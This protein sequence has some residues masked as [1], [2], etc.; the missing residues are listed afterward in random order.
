MVGWNHQQSYSTTVSTWHC[1]EAMGPSD[2]S[3][4]RDDGYRDEEDEGPDRDGDDRDDSG[5]P[6]ICS[7]K[8]LYQL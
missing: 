7:V 2:D 3:D 5:F 4:D 1:T 8:A 6:W